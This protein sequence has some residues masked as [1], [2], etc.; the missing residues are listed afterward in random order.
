MGAACNFSTVWRAIILLG[1]LAAASIGSACTGGS[2]QADGSVYWKGPSQWEPEDVSEL[3][4][5]TQTMVAPP[6]VPFHIQV[7]TGD[8][9]VVRVRL[10][11]EEKEIEIAPGVFVWA[12]T[13]NGWVPGPIIVVHEGDYV[14][15]T[16]VNPESNELLHNVDFHASIGALGGGELTQVPPGQEVVLTK[17]P[18]GRWFHGT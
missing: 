7:S 5:V 18:G 10:V 13:F 17:T 1:L 4:K 11:V 16:L 3:R 9:K 15:L 6:E 8:P 2:D 12:F 14:E